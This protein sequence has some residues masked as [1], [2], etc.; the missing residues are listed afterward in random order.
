MV[1]YAHNFLADGDG[2]GGAKTSVAQANETQADETRADE[3]HLT[4]A[5]AEELAAAYG[6]PLY[7]YDE[8]AIRARTR[9]LK[10]AFAWNP[11]FREYFAVK[12]TPD[13][14]IIQ[15]LAEEGCGCDCATAP[16]L[17]LA[18]AC[19]LTGHDMILTSND[20]PAADYRLAAELGAVINFDAADMP[21]FWEKH[22]GAFP[23]TACCRVNP[24]GTF[25]AANGIIG[26]P[27]DS[28]FGMTVPQLRETFAYLRDHGVEE[29]GVHAFLA[30]N[31]LGG[32]YYP[33]LA[34]QL[35]GLVADLARDLDI[36]IGFVD[37]SGGIG[38][39]YEPAD[40]D[41]ANDIAAIGQGV[42]RAY[43]DVLVPAGMGNVALYAELGRWL[44]APAGALLTRV[45]HEKETYRRYLGVD[46]CSANLMRPQ[47]YG[48]YHR[49]DVLGREDAPALATYN[50]VGGLCENGDQLAQ[51]RPLPETHPGDLLLIYDV[52]A[53]GYSMGYNY[54]GKLRSAE[55]LLRADG[56]T[57]LI[58]RAERVTDYFATLEA[59]EVGRRALA[60][61]DRW[62]GSRAADM[63]EADARGTAAE[64]EGVV[65]TSIDNGDSKRKL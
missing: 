13:P 12:A 14:S 41:R 36:H 55:V 46:A 62:Q 60:L 27:E 2:N 56:T 29:F 61:A 1:C 57:E 18:Q 21:A 4:V 6:T 65:V 45:I 33:R 32:D 24:G 37:L 16:E 35:F 59:T 51:D 9:A 34:R 53:H 25:E 48:A 47:L 40:A 15:V 42:R 11:G 5:W 63:S 3:I 43:E 31:T 44:L 50:V 19:G 39:P 26:T 8:A 23:R 22:I 7:L 30:S 28:K 17:L 58:R 52:G 38:I 54:N 49:I 20:T 10:E 64:S